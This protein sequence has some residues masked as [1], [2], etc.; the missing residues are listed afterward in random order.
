MGTLEAEEI[1]L[2]EGVLL[3]ADLEPEME[4]RAILHHL[5]QH[6]Q[7]DEV[8]RYDD[9]ADILRFLLHLTQP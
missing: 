5:C 6:H 2:D 7:V 3:E 9:E 8:L 4:V 1:I